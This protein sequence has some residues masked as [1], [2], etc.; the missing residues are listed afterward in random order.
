[1]F[2]SF[3]RESLESF[4]WDG[5]GLRS[6]TFSY[7]AGIIGVHHHTW[8]VLLKWGIPK[9]LPELALNHD[10]HILCFFSS[11]IVG[12]NVQPIIFL[13]KSVISLLSY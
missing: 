4:A 13:R 7:V 1:L 11:K 2:L 8:L 3:F 6:S 9:F 10:P 12:M 5:L